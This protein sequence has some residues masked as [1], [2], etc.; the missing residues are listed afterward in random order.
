MQQL[1]DFCAERSM[2]WRFITSASAHQN[3]CTE[4]LVKGCKFALKKTKGHQ[5]LIPFKLYTCLLKVA[6]LM[7]QRSI[8][9]IPNDSDDGSY[10]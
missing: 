8:G 4:A 7:N 1:K 2:K 3:G 5:V 10:L 9:R 6:N